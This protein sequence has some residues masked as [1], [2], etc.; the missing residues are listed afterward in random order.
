ML[1]SPVDWVKGVLFVATANL[2]VTGGGPGRLVTN[3]IVDV[4]KN[5]FFAVSAAAAVVL[6]V[7]YWAFFDRIKHAVWVFPAI[8]LWLGYRSNSHYFSFW[9]P[10]LLLSLVLAWKHGEFTQAARRS[11][12]PDLVEV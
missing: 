4:D 8:I 12:E 3:G 7:A 5:V 2:E 10:L 6:F 1:W 9:P 11:E